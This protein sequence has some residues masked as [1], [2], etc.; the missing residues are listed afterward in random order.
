[1]ANPLKLIEEVSARL[2]RGDDPVRFAE[3]LEVFL[4][5]PTRWRQPLVSPVVQVPGAHGPGRDLRQW[6]QKVYDDL[7]IQGEVPSVPLLSK[8]QRAAFRRFGLRQLF[9]PALEETAYPASFVKPAWG[10]YLDAASIERKPLSGIWVAI[11]TIQKPEWNDPAGYLNDRLAEKLA[12]KARFK[13][14]WDQLHQ[15]G[16]LAKVAQL[17]SFPK[18]R[19]RLPS[20]EEWNFLANL[21]N[22]LRTNRGEALPDLGSTNSWEWCENV[23][24]S[25]GRLF[26]GGREYGGL[27][28]VYSQLPGRPVDGITFRVLAVLS[29]A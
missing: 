2:D 18:T 5:D 19:V 10:K 23:Y 29:P 14:T 21:M 22:W 15:G 26:V 9:V 25:D 24:R 8:R 6:M 27:A 4:R 20:V 16:L 11:E 7:G 28:H 17:M 13:A 3:D 1:M 12:L